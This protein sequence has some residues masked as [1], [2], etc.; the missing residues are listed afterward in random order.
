M[1][2]TLSPNGCHMR[3]A[4][5]I[6]SIALLAALLPCI[7]T[8]QDLPSEA[9]SG[10]PIELQPA[11][12]A[13][14]ARQV[15][16]AD[17]AVQWDFANIALDLLLESYRQELHSAATERASTSGR[18]AKLASWRAGTRDLISRLESSHARLADGATLGIRVDA[19]D[20][21]LIVIEG[22]PVAVSALRP[23]AEQSIDEQ[24]LGR[25]CGYND[26]SVLA[27]G[28]PSDHHHPGVTAGTW[29][30]AP[31]TPPTFESGQLF[32]CEFTDTGSRRQKSEACSRAANEALQLASRLEQAKQRGY[33]IDWD[34]LA[35]SSPADLENGRIVVNRDGAY[36][37]MPTPT[38][39]KLVRADWQRLV[40]WLPSTTDAQRTA[41][42]IR[43]ATRLLDT[44]GQESGRP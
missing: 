40:A 34:L 10:G 23:D 5:L 30:F 21:V 19:Q 15:S 43:D 29:Y 8:A 38:L 3:P 9:R 36:I 42:V 16:Q 20:Q 27:G 31:N 41:L 33:R 12:L 26:C 4:H 32:R 1:P 37:E 28:S 17:A 25:F 2:T 22:L 24:I 6:H 39:W 11:R 7:S 35:N 44:T 13:T 18:R 14:V